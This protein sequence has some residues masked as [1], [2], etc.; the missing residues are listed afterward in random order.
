MYDIQKGFLRPYRSTG[1]GGGTGGAAGEGD[2]GK[3]E[4]KGETLTFEKWSESLTDEQK[5]LMETHT[6]GLKGALDSERTNAANLAKQ[7]KELSAKAEKGSELEKSLAELNSKLEDQN[8]Y[9]EFLEEA[10]KAGVSN[11]KLAW[12]A[13]KQDG[14]IDSKG[15]VNFDSLKKDY[16]ELFGEKQKSSGDA[17]AGAGGSG[18]K[19]DMNT[20]IR[21]AAGQAT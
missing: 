3:G 15:W 16:P 21:H 5:A 9:V 12:I 13:V 11:V 17:G 8:S 4:G 2:G 7:I 20:I 6:K 10:G 14:L 18:G 1:E 19:L